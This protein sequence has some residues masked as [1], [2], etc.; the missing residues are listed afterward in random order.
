MKTR[1]GWYLEGVSVTEE[2]A[3][4]GVSFQEKEEFE[5]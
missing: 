4:S 3:E 1:F 2:A 5:R